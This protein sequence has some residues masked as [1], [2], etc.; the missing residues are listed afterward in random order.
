MTLLHPMTYG[1][2]GLYGYTFPC[3]GCGEIH[4]IKTTGEPKW[5]FNGDVEKPTFSPSYLTWVDP[6]PNASPEPQYKKYREGFRCHSFIRDGKIEYLSD[7][8]HE[9][10]GQTLP[11]MTWE[12]YEAES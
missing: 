6:N 10:A 5:D 8:T 4:Q 11:M 9:L 12:E 7:C 3:R 1:N 2:G